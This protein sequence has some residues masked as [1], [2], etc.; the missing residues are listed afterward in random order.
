MFAPPIF[1]TWPGGSPGSPEL[2]DQGTEDRRDPAA[3][4]ATRPGRAGAPPR[5][6]P[7]QDRG[8][9]HR[10]AAFL[11]GTK[12]K[13]T[14]PAAG[15]RSRCLGQSAEQPRVLPGPARSVWGRGQ[16]RPPLPRRAPGD[17]LIKTSTPSRRWFASYLCTT[18]ATSP[19]AAAVPKH[20]R[21]D[22]SPAALKIPDKES[23]NS[24][25][26][27]SQSLVPAPAPPPVA[28]VAA[29]SDSTSRPRETGPRGRRETAHAPPGLWRSGRAYPR[30]SCARPAR[31]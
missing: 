1:P 22:S 11:Q 19:P 3:P 5:W 20:C 26:P 28:A 31:C 21:N 9:G 10:Q 4:P 8:S 15:G 16:A 18:A 17:L 13:L 7:R 27:T 23:R 24:R 14:P 12:V 6:V 2:G 30:L 25:F 29:A